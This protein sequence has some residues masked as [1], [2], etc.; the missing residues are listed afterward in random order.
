M[1]LTDSTLGFKSRSIPNFISDGGLHT[2]RG[3]GDFGTVVSLHELCRSSSSSVWG[4]EVRKEG[5]SRALEKIKGEPDPKVVD[6]D[7][8]LWKLW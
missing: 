3:L 1:S 6:V 5:D 7:K 8:E 2:G 4:R